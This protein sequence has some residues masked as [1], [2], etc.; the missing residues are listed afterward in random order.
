MAIADT[1]AVD[2]QPWAPWLIAQFIKGHAIGTVEMMA[3]APHITT[4]TANATAVVVVRGPDHA[5]P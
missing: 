1:I 4:F 3:G 5:H 2:D